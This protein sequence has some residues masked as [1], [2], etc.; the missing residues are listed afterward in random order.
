MDTCNQCHR[1]L[2]V[3]R[4]WEGLIIGRECP[5]HKQDYFEAPKK[6]ERIGKYSGRSKSP[7]AFNDYK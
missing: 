7:H 2:E 3:T 5:V 4:N 1:M 6:K